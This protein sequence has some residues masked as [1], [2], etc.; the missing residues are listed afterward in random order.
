MRNATRR[1]EK[2]PQNEKIMEY[3]LSC[4]KNIWQVG[5]NSKNTVMLCYKTFTICY[6]PFN[7]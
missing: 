6:K 2:N 1:S 5:L 7:Q 3:N 4:L